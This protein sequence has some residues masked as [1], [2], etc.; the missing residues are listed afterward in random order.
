MKPESISAITGCVAS[1]THSTK[2]I[3]QQWCACALA[4]AAVLTLATF[5]TT[6]VQAQTFE[7]LHRFKCGKSDGGGPAGGLV[8]DP[9]SNNLYGTTG[10]CGAH[11]LGTVFEVPA[12]GEETVLYSFPTLA[13]GA[14]PF[15]TL[16]RDA[17]GNLYGTTYYG[18]DVKCHSGLCGTVFKLTTNRKETV[19][20]RFEDGKDGAAPMAGV[21][22]DSK[23]NLY[24]TTVAGGYHECMLGGIYAGCGVVF[25]LSGN[26][27]KVKYSFKL[28]K[29]GGPEASLVMDASGNLY[30]TTFGS[31][32]VFE[33]SASGILTVLLTFTGPPD[34]LSPVSGLIRDKA[35][36][37]Y[38][39]TLQGGTVGVQWPWLRDDL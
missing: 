19:L 1:S 13:D 36:N 29:A 8:L 15:A 9:K 10:N 39:T 5:A 18:G 25:R 27:E 2:Q 30:G 31:Q 33:L 34:G 26:T 7:V 4:L 16:A 11:S 32:G 12:Q 38:G 37:L 21:I 14:F 3:R 22:L 24:G 17:T 20:H 28:P 35:G 6:S 23:G